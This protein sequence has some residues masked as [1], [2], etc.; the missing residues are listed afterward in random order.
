MISALLFMYAPF[1]AMVEDPST[2]PDP[3]VK[4]IEEMDNAPPEKRV[5]NWEQVRALMTRE[6]PKVG[7]AAPDFELKTLDGKQTLKLSQY[8]GKLPVVLIFGSYT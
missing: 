6:A 4:F 7:E 1:F 3:A 2:A 8:A 5:P